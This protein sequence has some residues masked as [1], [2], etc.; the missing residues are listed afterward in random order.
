[1]TFVKG[2]DLW[3]P[4]GDLQ[5]MVSKLGLDRPMD[6]SHLIVKHDGIKLLDHLTGTELS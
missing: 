5:K 2:Y 3:S 4:A 6:F 1:M